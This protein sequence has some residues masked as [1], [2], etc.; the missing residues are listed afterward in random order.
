M[1]VNVVDPETSFKTAVTSVIVALLP[2]FKAVT[3]PWLAESLEINAMCGFEVFQVT[4]FV[5][6]FVELSL[7]TPIAVN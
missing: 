2:I 6:S 5:R 4:L 1:T 3:S 7:N